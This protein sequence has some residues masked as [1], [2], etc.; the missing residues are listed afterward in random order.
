MAINTT[1]S[2]YNN[3]SAY[4]ANAAK[5]AKT[6]ASKETKKNEA[7]EVATKNE[8]ATGTVKQSEYGKTI[9]NAQLSEKGAKYYEK[10]KKKFGNLDFIL[11]S[12]DQKAT[13]Q[14]NAGKYANASKMVVLIDEEKIEKM[15]TDEKFRKQYEGVIAKAYSGMNQLKSSMESSGQSGQVKGYGIQVMDNGTVKYFA[16]LE[17]SA[18]AQSERIQKQSEK[19]AA[20]KKADKAKAEKKAR[21]ESIKGTGVEVGS[22]DEVI[23]ADS[24]EELMKKVSDYTYTYKSDSIKTP[25]EMQVGQSIDFR[26]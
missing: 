11:V 1:N 12:K 10:L 18:K 2:I 13:A 14:A 22:D 26:G 7:K 9:G 25:E 20:E 3:Y 4:D 19:K 21:E 8:A 24:V 5:T 23:F 17:K 15:A 6:D 16:V